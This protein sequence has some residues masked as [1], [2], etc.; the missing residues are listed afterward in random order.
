MDFINIKGLKIYGYHGVL[1]EEKDEGQEFL[2]DAKL[3]FDMTNAGLLDE[4]DLTVD[5][6]KVSETVRETFLEKKYDL[7]ETVAE[8]V[9]REILI[10]YAMV[11][12][13][14]ITIHKPHAPIP[15]DFDDVSVN[16]KR[17]WNQVYLGVGSNLGDRNKYIQDAIDS[18][19]KDKYIKDV[20]CST[21]IETKPYGN[22]E[23]GDF[24]N[25]VIELWTLM[26]PKELLNRLH[27]IE[28]SAKRTREIHWGPRTLDLDILFYENTIMSTDELSIPHADIENRLFVLEPLC[29]LNSSL[30]NPKNN[31]T[32]NE[33]LIELRAR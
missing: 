25:G 29:E 14:Y 32:V 20:K 21:L 30:V 4:L 13:V 3:C 11:E 27:E 16:I 18:L 31:K 9:A 7:I 28:S 1:K 10:N 17:K 6:S 12:E 15:M 22:V 2:I 24:L 8:A 26:N 19:N 33:M 23:Q 5:Y